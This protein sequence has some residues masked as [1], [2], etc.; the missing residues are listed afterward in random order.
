[1]AAMAPGTVEL[2]ILAWNQMLTKYVKDGQ[3]E[4]S[5]Q[6]DAIFKCSDLD[7]HD[8]RTCETWV[9]AEDNFDTKVHGQALLLLWGC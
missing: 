2:N 7:H 9:R 4:K 5:V 6:Q 3:P 8:I 1:M